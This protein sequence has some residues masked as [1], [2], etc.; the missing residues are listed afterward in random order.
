MSDEE[1]PQVGAVHETVQRRLR[2][3][4]PHR[5]EEPEEKK[6]NAARPHRTFVFVPFKY[7]HLADLQE[8]SRV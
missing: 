4:I 7:F 6:S 2:R 1:A 3:G 8:D 5:L